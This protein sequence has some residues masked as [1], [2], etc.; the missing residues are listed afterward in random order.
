MQKQEWK[1]DFCEIWNIS[2]SNQKQKN[3]FRNLGVNIYFA[4]F[5]TLYFEFIELD[6]C[7][8]NFF[9]L[10]HTDKEQFVTWHNK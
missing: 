9:I 8:P 6:H 4:F 3:T 10:Q 5:V 2:C 7:L 1:T